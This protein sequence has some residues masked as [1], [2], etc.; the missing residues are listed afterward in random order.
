MNAPT[1][2]NEVEYLIQELKA[3]YPVFS[4][5]TDTVYSAL[6]AYKAES[7]YDDIID[8]GIED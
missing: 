4:D 7:L 1:T 8:I 6:N 5:I 3:T 2:Y